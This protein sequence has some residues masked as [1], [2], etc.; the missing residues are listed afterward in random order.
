MGKPTTILIVDEKG[1]D[2]AHLR[3]VLR[4][5]GFAV[6]EAPDGPR[7]LALLERQV[8]DLALLEIRTPGMGDF[9]LLERIRRS[10]PLERLPVIILTA[11]PKKASHIE[12]AFRLGAGAYLTKPVDGEEVVTYVR[13][14]LR[15][16]QVEEEL[17]EKNRELEQVSRFK[18]QFLASLSHELRT[19]LNSIIGFSELLWEQSYGPLNEKQKR[20]VSNIL[21]SGRH[22]LSLINDI[23]DLSKIEAGRMELHPEAFSLQEALE[24]SVAIISSLASKSNISLEL[25]RNGP[26]GTVRADP[27]RFKQ[28]MYNLLSNAVKFTPEGGRVVVAVRRPPPG[29]FV[30]ISVADTGI[31]IAPED[32][33][34]IF[35]EFQ[36]IETPLVKA[37]EGTGLGLPLT[38]KLVELHGGRIWVES[39][40]GHGSTF[41]F[42][43]PLSGP[44]PMP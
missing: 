8:P 39:E 43:L 9:E 3:N 10:R 6:L 33:E 21:E 14:V 12:R 27:A 35:Q 29:E 25:H 37:K 19:P 7:C 15:R 17:R 36:R 40:V 44:A 2:R 24:A 22:L 20:H 1:D 16:K 30:E 23:L 41:T 34:R 28:I 4:K 11:L 5:Q 18:S 38:K 32:H 31:G 42:T 13:A 26:L